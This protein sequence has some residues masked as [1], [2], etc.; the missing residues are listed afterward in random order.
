MK[1][2]L[3]A[4]FLCLL[5]TLIPAVTAGCSDSRVNSDDGGAQ[6][7]PTSDPSADA[8][9]AEE[10]EPTA[11]KLVRERY[12]DTN[13]QGYEYKVLA[14]PTDGHFYSQVGAGINEV[15]AEEMNG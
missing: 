14:I 5:L 3:T 13:L 7:N 15:Y 2:R 1:K 9:E 4:L 11:T 6:Q 10:A 12:A 8:G